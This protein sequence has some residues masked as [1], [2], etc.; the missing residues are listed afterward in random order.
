MYGTHSH[1]TKLGLETPAAK[2]PQPFIKWVGGKRSLL[3]EIT[4]RLPDKFNN[5]FEPFVGG[6]A[7]FFSLS[8]KISKATLVD[9]NLELVLA[10]RVIQNE[11]EA[12]IKKLKEFSDKHSKEYFYQVRKRERQDPVSIAARFLYLNKTCYNGLYRVNK[13]GLFNVPVGNYNNPNIIQAEN[14]TSCHQALK[15]AVIS[16]GDFEQITPEKGD[17]VYFDPPYHPT[18]ELSFTEYT[19]E[20][21][22]EKDQVRLRDFIHAL[23]KKGVFIMLSNSKTKLI[24]DLY[25]ARYFKH[26]VI[27]APRF[28][29]CKPGGRSN[30]E[31]LLITNY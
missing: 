8:N 25:R 13:K 20:N 10:Y 11:P 6:G 16:F 7:L 28:V 23:H 14:I 12:L 29:N 30:V 1:H 18:D 26:N 4:S 24:E 15:K 31:E 22:T 27:H 9:S 21:F 17:F 3:Q 2:E 19:K 5:Y